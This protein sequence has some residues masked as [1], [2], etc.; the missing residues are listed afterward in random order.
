MGPI[1]VVVTPTQPS[2]GYVPGYIEGDFIEHVS[3]TSS[4]N[5]FFEV[6]DPSKIINDQTYRI[7]FTDTFLLKD[8]PANLLPYDI[9]TTH[10]WYLENITTGDTL[11]KPEFADST[12]TFEP[13]IDV[14]NGIW[15]EGEP[16]VDL[17]GNGEWDDADANSGNQEWDEAMSTRHG[18][19]WNP[20]Y[21][22]RISPGS[23][24]MLRGDGNIK[25]DAVSVYAST[26][27]KIEFI[28]A[29]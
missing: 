7:T 8:T 23:S 2:S 22:L 3:G 9:L 10:F 21:F 17:N 28:I 27:S 20:D 16:L 24:I 13:F 26:E 15:D 14:G 29:K 12:L 4:G 18:G 6:I 19:Y 11:I 1:V 5:V 25:C